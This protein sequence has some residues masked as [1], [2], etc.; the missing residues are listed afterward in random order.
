MNLCTLPANSKDKAA[1]LTVHSRYISGVGTLPLTSGA[2]SETYGFNSQ[3]S[4]L[5]TTNSTRLKGS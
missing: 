5:G 2:R 3:F 1:K 4:R